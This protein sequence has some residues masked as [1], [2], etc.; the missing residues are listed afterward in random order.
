[1]ELT[2][3]LQYIRTHLIK[4]HA[5]LYEWLEEPEMVHNYRPNPDSWTIAEILEHV[6]LTSHYLLLLID[7]GAAK[8]KR[9]ATPEAIE[10]AIQQNDFDLHRLEII[11]MHKAFEWIRPE[12]MEPS[13]KKTRLEIQE[14]LADQL[15]RCLNHLHDLSAGEGLL[16]LTTMTVA[17]LGKLNVYE[18]I[19]FLSLHAQRHLE[20]MAKNKAA[21]EQYHY[22]ALQQKLGMHLPILKCV[23]IDQTE[24]LNEWMKRNQLDGAQAY[25]LVYAFWQYL[26]FLPETNTIPSLEPEVEEVLDRL[27]EEKQAA[28][29]AG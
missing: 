22:Q 27:W 20:Q 14:T 15:R 1:M 11:G 12:H 3:Y 18:Y 13:G 28:E 23:F 8:A 24:D 9:K 2:Q 4:T 25:D 17:D 6:A 10:T 7:K 21:F 16:Q 19:F 5:A 26:D 29:S